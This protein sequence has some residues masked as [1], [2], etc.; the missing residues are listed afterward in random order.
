VRLSRTVHSPLLP[1][2][3]PSLLFVRGFWVAVPTVPGRFR[4]G[5]KTGRV[6]SGIEENRD[7][8]ARVEHDF[9]DDPGLARLGVRGAFQVLREISLSSVGVGSTSTFASMISAESALMG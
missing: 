1:V 3:Y 7:P 2:V 9:D 5:G 8:E 4:H 6:G